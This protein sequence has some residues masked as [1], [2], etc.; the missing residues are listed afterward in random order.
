MLNSLE[1]VTFF[2]VFTNILRP[3]VHQLKCGLQPLVSYFQICCHL[4]FIFIF[5]FLLSFF[6]FVLSEKPFWDENKVCMYVCMY[7]CS[8]GT[9][10]SWLVRSSP[11]RTV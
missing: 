6:L 9:V 3:K 11:D 10:A 8:G 4:V 5:F 2:F 7:V 1:N